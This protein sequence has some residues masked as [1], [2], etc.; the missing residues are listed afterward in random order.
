[1]KNKLLKI[2]AVIAA[3]FVLITKSFAASGGYSTAFNPTNVLTA[4]T[5]S[6]SGF[7]TNLLSAAG[8][9]QVT[10]NTPIYVG[11]VDHIG[12]NIQGF[13][14]TTNTN[15][16]TI[17]LTFVTSMA[18]SPPQIVYGVSNIWTAG[19]T[20]VMTQNDWCN[21]N[22][23]PA[24]SLTFTT[25]TNALNGTYTTN[26]INLQTNLPTASIAGDV[27][28]LGL[29]AITNNLSTGSILTNF[30]VYVNQKLEVKPFSP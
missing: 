8:L 17:G 18:T 30:N 22:I 7:P 25:L 19:L 29:Y 3:S 1:M 16:T 2:G 11:Y 14:V 21:P 23:N 24:L 12:I 28:W 20:N 27:N 5:P 13:L 4:S 15:A 26:W 10:G 6:V 9:P